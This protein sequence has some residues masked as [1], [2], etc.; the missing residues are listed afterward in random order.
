[1]ISD[2]TA[3]IKSIRHRLGAELDFDLDRIVQDTL[4]RQAESGRVYIRLPKRDPQVTNRCTGA[5]KSGGP[6]VD[7]QSSPPRD[8]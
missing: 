7:N 6:E 5:A 3:E 4:R 1:M 8:R 2:P